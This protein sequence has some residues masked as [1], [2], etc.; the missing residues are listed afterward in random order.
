MLLKHYSYSSSLA[1]IKA[2]VPQGSTFG[3]L[4]FILYFNDIF[5]LNTQ[6]D[7]VVYPKA[8]VYLSKAKVRTVLLPIL[9]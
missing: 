8:T 9:S 7:Y 1:N 6:A 4:V 3:P 2:D 5:Q